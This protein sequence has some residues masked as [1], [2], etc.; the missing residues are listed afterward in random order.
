MI[1]WRRRAKAARDDTVSQERLYELVNQTLMENF[2]PLGSFAITRRSAADTDDIFHT[3]LARS[4]AHDIVANLAEHGI[5]VRSSLSHAAA[6]LAP[7]EAVYV[8]RQLARAVSAAAPAMAS[9][10]PP[11]ATS[12]AP[13]LTLAP[14][15][16]ATAGPDPE[17]DD[18]LRSLVA[19]HRAVTEAAAQ[20]NAEGG[21]SLAR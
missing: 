16:V 10:A 7:V 1:G 12:V 21:W 13:T 8:P 14:A 19:H 15:A 11:A 20:K 9:A 17:D 6:P 18:A 3:S 5:S 2:G 4:V